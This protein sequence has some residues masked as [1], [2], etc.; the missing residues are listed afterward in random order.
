MKNP[1]RK[2]ESFAEKIY[3]HYR[4]LFGESRVKESMASGATDE[5]ADIIL[6]LQKRIV[7]ECKHHKSITLTNLRK[8]YDKLLLSTTSSDIPV[9]IYRENYRPIMAYFN[10]NDFFPSSPIIFVITTQKEFDLLL[11][12]IK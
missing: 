2:G 3:K 11:E 6:Y 8:F 7:I 12:R 9:I 5:P 10:L 4:N 1:K